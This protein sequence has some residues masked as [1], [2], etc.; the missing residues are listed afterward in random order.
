[1]LM[2]LLIIVSLA[3]ACRSA[4]N[5]GGLQ[6]SEEFTTCN[7][8]MAV[9]YTERSNAPEARSLLRY[10]LGA[11]VVLDFLPVMMTLLM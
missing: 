5:T 10:S 9:N 3:D 4:Q 1:M 6:W 8:H 11:G 7:V 2:S